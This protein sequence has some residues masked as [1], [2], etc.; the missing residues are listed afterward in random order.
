M[1]D[2]PVDPRPTQA[3]QAKKGSAGKRVSLRDFPKE[4]LPTTPAAD[5]PS[6]GVGKQGGAQKVNP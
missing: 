4:W 2:I 3:R 5:A 6:A 1:T